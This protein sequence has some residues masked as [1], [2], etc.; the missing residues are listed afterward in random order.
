M[1]ALSEQPRVTA[2]KLLLGLT[3]IGTGTAAGALLD[4]E[5]GD[6]VQVSEA[7]L[8]VAQRSVTGMEAELGGARERIERAEAAL[9]RARQDAR[10]LARSNRRLRRELR[11]AQRAPR[12]ATRQR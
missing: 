9:E 6:R 3:L 12:Q 4:S 8:A 11:T 5:D 1:R 7:R 10:R 2:A